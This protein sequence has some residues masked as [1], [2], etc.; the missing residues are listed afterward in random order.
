MQIEPIPAARARFRARVAAC[1][2][3]Q[4]GDTLI[5][6]M[7]AALLVALIATASLTGF[8]AVAHIAGSQRNEEQAATLAQQDQARLR[9][10]DITQLSGASGNQSLTTAPIDGTAYTVVSSSQFI[11]GG[12]TGTS[13]TASCTTVGATADEV[14]T[15]STVTWGANNDGRAAVVI[16]GLVTPAQGGSLIVSAVDQNGPLAGV[17]ATVTGKT[18]ADGTAAGTTTVS[19]LITNSN[20]CAV[21]GGLAGGGYNVAFS[22]PGYLDVNGHPQADESTTVV[23]TRTASVPQI[24]I[25]KPG[26]ISATFTSFYD[27]SLHLGATADQLS[28]LNNAITPVTIGF[29]SAPLQNNYVPSLTTSLNLFPWVAN[30]SGGMYSYYAGACTGD[31]PPPG[32]PPQPQALYVTP[33]TN[34][35]VVQLPAMLVLVW[36]SSAFP[37]DDRSSAFS[38]SSG[39]SPA[40][41]A[42]DVNNTETSSSTLNNTVTATFTG[43]NVQLIAPT[44][45]DHG[46]AQITLDSLTPVN[47]DEYSA[48][49]KPQQVVWS[50]TGLTNTTH[51]IKITVTNTHNASSSGYAVT[52]DAITG[53][54]TLLTTKQPN[55]TVT[56]NNTGCVPPSNEDYPVEQIPTAMPVTQIPTSAQGALQN[57]GQPY[58]NLT[59]CADDGTNSNTATVANVSYV[60]YNIYNIY[61]GSGSPNRVAAKCP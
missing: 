20:G 61:L 59:V 49:T 57:P 9:G 30:S 6:V 21:F 7:I 14:Q 26:A 51:T 25:A 3:G 27:G 34:A 11:A 24:Q 39:W 22:D 4:R 60:A 33:G 56:D 35:V 5:E 54:G 42:G 37:L 48:T 29:D 46:I 2:R 18:L 52:V 1:S 40:S 13:G 31:L 44:A 28:F 32:A 8:G 38:Y 53:T 17:I 10:L 47:V 43:T 41:V 15:T 19:P 58:G 55:V 45:P 23:P 16:H 12:A 36:A 50:A